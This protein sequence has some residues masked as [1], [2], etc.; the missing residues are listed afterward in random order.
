M[1]QL[2]RAPRVVSGANLRAGQPTTTTAIGTSRKTDCH[3]SV[4]VAAVAVGVSA[5]VSAC[6]RAGQPEVTQ[7]HGQLDSRTCLSRWLHD[8]R[9]YDGPISLYHG[10]DLN[11]SSINLSS[12]SADCCCRRLSEMTAPKDLP[13]SLW[14]INII[15]WRHHH[16]QQTANSTTRAKVA[17][18][19]R[20]KCEQP[21]APWIGVD[22]CSSS[23]ESDYRERFF[24]ALTR[25][26]GA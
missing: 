12:S 25:P 2:A 18:A 10:A 21:S 6:S 26:F 24:L 16:Q 15:I 9:R 22:F 1:A 4:A 7:L 13:A 11:E 5:S 17:R 8:D 19:S 14:P 20:V 23:I 3:S